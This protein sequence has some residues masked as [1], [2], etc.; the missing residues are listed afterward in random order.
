MDR[1]PRPCLGIENRLAFYPDKVEIYAVDAAEL[2]AH[3][4]GT[5]DPPGSDTDLSI[6]VDEVV[7]HTDSGSGASQREHW[8]ANV[9]A[10]E[11]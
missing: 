1:D 6:T 3:Q 2:A 10:P 5:P 8:P 9:S 4:R 11:G 7:Q